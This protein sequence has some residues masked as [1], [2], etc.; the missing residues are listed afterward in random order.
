MLECG[1][2]FQSD[3]FQI[4]DLGRKFLNP[5]RVLHEHRCQAQAEFC[6]QAYS[7]AIYKTEPS[8]ANKI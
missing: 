1:D 5:F 8:D 3:T 4:A 6:A 2:T 7:F